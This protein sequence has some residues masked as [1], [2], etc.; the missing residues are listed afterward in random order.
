MSQEQALKTLEQAINAANLKGVY[1][2]EDIKL[3]LTALNTIKI[4]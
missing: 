3:I 2:L 1:S 4:N